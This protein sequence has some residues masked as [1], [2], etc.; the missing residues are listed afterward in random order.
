MVHIDQWISLPRLFG[1][2][3]TTHISQFFQGL[4][5]GPQQLGSHARKGVDPMHLQDWNIIEGCLEVE[6][7]TIWTVEKQR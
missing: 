5:R 7:P 1:H 6:L 4:S 2:L 3:T